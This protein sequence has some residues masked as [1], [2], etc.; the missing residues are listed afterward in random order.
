VREYDRDLDKAL[1]FNEP[2]I[3]CRLLFS[4]AR[5]FEPVNFNLLPDGRESG[6]RIFVVSIC[7]ASAAARARDCSYRG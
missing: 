2:F 4:F 6:K 5:A 7:I 1:I 3:W